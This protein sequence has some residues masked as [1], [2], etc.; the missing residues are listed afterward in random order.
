MLIKTTFDINDKT[1]VYAIC[2]PSTE[3]CGMITTNIYKAIQ[4]G[5]CKDFNEVKLLINK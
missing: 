3:R 4:A 5:K 2:D 1:P